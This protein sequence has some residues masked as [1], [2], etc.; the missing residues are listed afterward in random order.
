[1]ERRP[2]AKKGLVDPDPDPLPFPDPFPMR[3]GETGGDVLNG[4]G[5]GQGER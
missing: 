5:V 4:V 2:N 1:M 3:V